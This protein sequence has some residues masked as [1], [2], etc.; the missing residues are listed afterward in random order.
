M[1]KI[2][3]LALAVQKLIARLKFQREWQNDRQD[4]NNMI[5]DLGG[6]IRHYEKQ[7][8]KSVEFGTKSMHFESA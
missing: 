4:K 3:A 6:I 7:R 5:F 1:S 8:K 2:K